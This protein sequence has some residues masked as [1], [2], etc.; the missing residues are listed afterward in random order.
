MYAGDLRAR[1]V[2]VDGVVCGGGKGGVSKY[3]GDERVMETHT[4]LYMSDCY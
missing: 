2:Q 1:C 3:A 4:L